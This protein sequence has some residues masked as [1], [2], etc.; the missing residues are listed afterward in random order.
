[1]LEYVT[2]LNLKFVVEE[3]NAYMLSL[4]LMHTDR[5]SGHLYLRLTYHCLCFLFFDKN[6]W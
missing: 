6:K 3:N 5:G 2:Y 1:M 4:P